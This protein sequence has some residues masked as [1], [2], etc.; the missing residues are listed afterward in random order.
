MPSA[1][2]AADPHAALQREDR[3]RRARPARPS[4][5]H[6]SRTTTIPELVALSVSTGFSRFPVCGTD[7]DD[8]VGVVHVKDVYRVPFD[9]RTS[10]TVG[11]GHD[12]AVRRARER[13][14]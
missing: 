13:A 3:G 4:D 14:T 7:L 9:E 6:A 11:V 2:N 12:R 8:V 5:V 10:A 1:L